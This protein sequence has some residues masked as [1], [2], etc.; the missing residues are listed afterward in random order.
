[1]KGLKK[2]SFSLSLARIVPQ[3]HGPCNFCDFAKMLQNLINF[4]TFKLALPLA[5]LALIIGGFFLIIAGGNVGRIEKGKKA[6]FGG[7]IGLLIIFG[8]WL[9]INTFLYIF[10]GGNLSEILGHPWYKIECP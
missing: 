9:L 10:T 4:L 6:I 1:M 7:I 2:I 8:A 3:C 5:T